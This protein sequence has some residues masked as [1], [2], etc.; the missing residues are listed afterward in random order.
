[1]VASDLVILFLIYNPKFQERPMKL[2]FSLA[3]NSNIHTSSYDRSWHKLRHFDLYDEV[4][5]IKP[6]FTL[7]Y[8]FKIRKKNTLPGV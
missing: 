3:G 5:S 7:D 4:V 2:M 1:M 6:D 8:Q